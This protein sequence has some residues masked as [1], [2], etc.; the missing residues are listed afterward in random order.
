VPSQ[1][2][3]IRPD[4]L[5]LVSVGAAI[6]SAARFE[7]S[8]L[9]NQSADLS[10]AF[11]AVVVACFATGLVLGVG[12]RSQATPD[13]ESRIYWAALGLSGGFAGVSLYAIVGAV[14]TRVWAGVA[15]LLFTPIVAIC[16][17]AAGALLARWAQRS[18]VRR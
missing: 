3:P 10:D 6:G 16:S 2:K 14:T 1:R 12:G 13:A 11:V 15:Y 4:L 7:I 17:F 5:L 9:H 8:N 18:L